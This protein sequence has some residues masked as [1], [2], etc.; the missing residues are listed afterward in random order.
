MRRALAL[1]RRGWGWTAPNPMVGAV[2]VRD[3]EVVGEGWHTAFGE[4][5][6]EVEALNAAGDRAR[7]A[8]AYVTL[9]PCNHAGKT[10]PCAPALIAAG[11]RRVVF[12][13]SDPNPVAA[14]GASALRAAGVTV[15]EGLLGEESRELNAAFHGRFG[16]E[17]PFITLKLAVSLDGAIAKPGMSGWLTGPRARRAVHRMRA[18]HDAIAIGSGTAITD[19]PQL[20]VRGVRKPRVAPLRVVFDR[21]GRLT[22]ALRVVRTA[23]ALP[24]LVLTGDPAPAGV[25]SLAAHGVQV[26][27]A[28]S[29]EAAL[30]ALLA[31]GV[32]S[33]LC[34]GGGE[35]AGSLVQAG[36]VDRLVIFQ[37]PVVLG[38]GA[39]RAFSYAAGTPAPAGGNWHI[40]EHSVLGDDL[41]TVYAPGKRL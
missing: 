27:S 30:R 11:V 29:L 32:D 34:E 4:A 23:R 5:H 7:G 33:L 31:R 39:V 9:E 41:M 18:G 14:G 8:T 13:A 22:A 38:A 12:A 28:A 10:P 36:A 40:V 35:L 6:A 20:T 25:Q 2:L 16:R 21:R 37:A 3:G 19:D 17:R 24:T 26:L 1:A 15:D